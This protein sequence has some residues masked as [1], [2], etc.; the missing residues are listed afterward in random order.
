MASLTKY[1]EVDL[2]GVTIHDIRH[3][4]GLWE[5]ADI[6]LGEDY[7]LTINE[8]FLFACS[9]LLHDA[10]LTI[11]AYPGGLPALKG[12]YEWR[13]AE[14]AFRRVRAAQLSSAYSDAEELRP[15]DE[16]RLSFDL[17]RKRHAEQAEKLRH[18]PD[19]AGGPGGAVTRA[20]L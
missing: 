2:R 8:A 13:N 17:L 6:I 11:A 7:P 15:E 10:G 5:M 18:L 4:D 16:K 3:L 14:I 19:G 12:S 9:S 1:I 20:P